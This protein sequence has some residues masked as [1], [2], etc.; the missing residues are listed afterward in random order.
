M[1]QTWE[2]K[3]TRSITPVWYQMWQEAPASAV[4]PLLDERHGLTTVTRT[5]LEPWAHSSISFPQNAGLEGVPLAAT[6]PCQ[7][8]ACQMEDK[9]SE[10]FIKHYFLVNWTMLTPDSGSW[11]LLQDAKA[12][13]LKGDAVYTALCANIPP[14]L[15]KT[16][17]SLLIKSESVPR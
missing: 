4:K 7:T 3:P 11:N 1:L 17:S 9:P 6:I 14:E 15:N 10:K 5:S 13:F 16:I 8:D 12:D 2:A